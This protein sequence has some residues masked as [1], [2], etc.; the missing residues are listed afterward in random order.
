MQL[1]STKFLQMAERPLKTSRLAHKKSRGQRTNAN[2]GTR[3]NGSLGG[4][5]RPGRHFQPDQELRSCQIVFLGQIV[6]IAPQGSP[7]C[8]NV[9][10]KI[11]GD[12]GGRIT[13][14]ALNAEKFFDMLAN[15]LIFFVLQNKRPS[16]RTSFNGLPESGRTTLLHTAATEA[17]VRKH[18]SNARLV[19]IAAHGCVDYQNDNL[20][21]A[22]VLSPGS[23]TSDAQNDG[24]LQLREIYSLNLSSCELAVLS[25]CQ[26]YVGPERPLEAGTSMARAFL[27]QGA[28]RVICSQ[29]STDDRA[30][31][32][33]MKSFFDSLQSARRDGKP[34]DYAAALHDAKLSL[35]R[36]FERG[37]MPKYW[38]AFVLVGAP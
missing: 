25:A 11:S 18:I 17:E 3:N 34:V 20:F 5:R 30:T 1:L 13:I 2:R 23:D 4:R 14:A 37:S 32:D 26:T 31:T 29:W 8:L 6:H 27:E 33:L 16:N 21:G 24:L 35:R 22:L 38:A 36:D 9:A 12:T 19:H 10:G 7:Q 15:R 28:Q